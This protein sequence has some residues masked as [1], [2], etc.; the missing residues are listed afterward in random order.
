MS[1]PKPEPETR[2]GYTPLPLGRGPAHEL[3]AQQ[4]RAAI[5][6]G[7][8]QPGD[9]LPTE[10]ELREAFGVSRATI[11]EALGSLV[12]QGLIGKARGLNGGSFVLR[13]SVGQASESLHL[14]LQRL[15]QSDGMSVA[16]VVE[17]RYLLELPA[18]RLAASRR[19]DDDIVE[20][21]A[22]AHRLGG[23]D[24]PEPTDKRFHRAVAVASGNRLLQMAIEP[25]NLVLGEQL[26]VSR[27]PKGLL[28]EIDDDHEA[29]A[30]AIVAGDA[31][32]SEALMRDHLDALA[33]VISSIWK[34][35]G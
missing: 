24:H 33:A 34:R 1:A 31:D 6:S 3:V 16:E 29:I 5:V 35:P 20:L 23:A 26:D 7:E 4:L 32:R 19:T 18:A 17:S 30:E 8:L 15:G 13:P 22:C 27:Y 9:R 2:P 28:Q 14:S 21:R 10:I 12:G 25:I 11:R